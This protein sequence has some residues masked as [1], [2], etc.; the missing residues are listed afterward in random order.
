CARDDMGSGFDY[1]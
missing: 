1:W